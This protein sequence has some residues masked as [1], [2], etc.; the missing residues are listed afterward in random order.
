[1]INE[2]K[3]EI[4]K[5][6][7]EY[8]FYK[9][10]EIP[11]YLKD[12]YNIDVSECEVRQVILELNPNI[13]EDLKI[14]KIL[15]KGLFTNEDI[16]DIYKMFVQYPFMNVSELLDY[17]YK[18]Y[19]SKLSDAD[20]RK[21]F[22]F[23][24]IDYKDE[25]KKNKK[26]LKGLLNEY[27]SAIVYKM[28]SEFPY[29]NRDQLV[30]Y[31]KIEY[32]IDTNTDDLA[33]FLRCKY[34]KL[35]R[36]DKNYY[37]YNEGSK[38]KS[39]D[40]EVVLEM[41]VEGYSQTEI[42]ELLDISQA[43]VSKFYKS[44]KEEID[45]HRKENKYLKGLNK[46]PL[47][48]VKELWNETQNISN[49]LPILN[50][51][52]ANLSWKDL[53]Y[54]LKNIIVVDKKC[55]Y[56]G[57][58]IDFTSSNAYCSSDCSRKMRGEQNKMRSF[59]S[60]INNQGVKMK[61]FNLRKRI[62][63]ADNR[64]FLCKEKLEIEVTDS[65]NP[66][67]PVLTHKISNSNDGDNS[68]DNLIVTC[69]CCMYLKGSNNYDKYTEEEYKKNRENKINRYKNRVNLTDE[70]FLKDSKEGYSV[71][72]LSDR[73]CVSPEIIIRKRKELG[74]SKNTR[75]KKGKKI[76][77]YNTVLSTVYEKNYANS[78]P[79]RII[80]SDNK[81]VDVKSWK[82]TFIEICEFLIRK[83]K[84]LFIYHALKLLGRKS[85]YFSKD[86]ED[87]KKPYYLNSVALYFESSNSANSFMRIIVKL[88]ESMN[89]DKDEILIERVI[90]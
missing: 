66:L 47:S 59:N 9:Q 32:G 34:G 25:R 54:I 73:Y 46:I 33:T 87:L 37:L 58:S 39:S 17:I 5:L 48:E 40:K 90:F 14:N 81:V 38:M 7:S 6:Y 4:L 19:N 29:Y 31:I 35:E 89:V 28:Y 74:L 76:N 65:N 70:Q 55:K 8:P 79:V 42:A 82:E 62:K 71:K 56:C 20:L 27:Q 30:E 64:C 41:L 12:K 18:N 67:Y 36:N 49:M 44:N 61:E 21:L 72:D 45:L 86:K 3:K 69:K 1:M 22:K 43:Y 88:L 84:Q 75:P 68:E 50:N 57:K 80:F 51:K 52:G 10:T 78:K 15:M 53:R 13:K 11:K 23:I 2:Y 60:R 77:D 26:I 16:E 24:N 63:E 85:I 83:D